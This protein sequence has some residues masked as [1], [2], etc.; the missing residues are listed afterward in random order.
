MCFVTVTVV[1]L[2]IF[3]TL[4]KM[5]KHGWKPRGLVLLPT[6]SLFPVIGLIALTCRM[7]ETAWCGAECL[8]S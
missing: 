6:A 1:I 4:F 3:W 5:G 7:R 2:A 8:G